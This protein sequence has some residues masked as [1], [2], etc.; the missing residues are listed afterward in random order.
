MSEPSVELQ[1]RQDGT[2]EARMES[3]TG[4]VTVTLR[5][6]DLGSVTDGALT[7]DEETA[8]AVLLFLLEHQDAADLPK[9]I[10]GE[11]VVAAYDDAVE[12]IRARMG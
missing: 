2:Y 6:D 11:Q 4:P 5:L 10:D 9:Q 8:R 3:F 7:G 12:R 1:P